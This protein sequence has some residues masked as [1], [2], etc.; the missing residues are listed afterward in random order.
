MRFLLG[1]T[2]ARQKVNDGLSFDLEFA[3]QLVN[4]DLIY[5]SHAFFC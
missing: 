4:S 1:Y 5:V 2:E 3:G